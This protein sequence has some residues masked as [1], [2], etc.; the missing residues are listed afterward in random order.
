MYS[1]ILL[2]NL[3]FLN[4]YLSNC[5]NNFSPWLNIGTGVY[6]RNN[7]YPSNVNNV[8]ITYSGYRVPEIP[9]KVGITKR[10]F[11]NFEI[12]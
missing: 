3:F 2:L 5:Q 7:I 1:K 9:S 10:I 12:I 4:I 6:Y 11:I 8:L